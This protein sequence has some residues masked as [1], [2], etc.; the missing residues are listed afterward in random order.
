MKEGWRGERRREISGKD[1]REQKGLN[2]IE[3]EN[4]REKKK[5]VAKEVKAH[6]EGALIG[7]RAV[8]QHM[9]CTHDCVVLLRAVAFF[10]DGGSSS[11]PPPPLLWRFRGSNPVL[12]LVTLRVC[13]VHWSILYTNPRIDRG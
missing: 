4:M 3:G 6:R 13:R 11:P 1:R 12:P 9:Y 2:R 10:T 7:T 8:R 5:C